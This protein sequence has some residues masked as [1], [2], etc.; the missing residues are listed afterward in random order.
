[1]KKNKL[2]V[3][4]LFAAGLFLVLPGA[5]TYPGALASDAGKIPAE[6]GAVG[7]IRVG[8]S[9]FFKD[10]GHERLWTGALLAIDDGSAEIYIGSTTEALVVANR[11]VPGER[12]ILSAVSFYTSG[13]AVGDPAEIIVYEDPTGRAPAPD[14]SMEVLRQE[15]TLGQGGF[16]GVDIS[17]FVLNAAGSPEA[18]FFVGLVNVAPRSFSLGIDMS[19]AGG[20]SFI[21]EDGGLRVAPIAEFPVIDGNAMIRVHRA[22][23]IPYGSAE[24][25]L[26]RHRIRAHVMGAEQAELTS[27]ETESFL[28]IGPSSG[29]ERGSGSRATLI[30]DRISASSGSESCPTC[31]PALTPGYPRFVVGDPDRYEDY[32]TIENSSGSGIVMPIRTILTSLTPGTVEAYNPDGGGGRPPT[33]YWDYSLS[34]A[35]GTDSEDDI[36]DPG[37]K[38]TRL[39]Q[40]ANDGGVLFEF[41]ADVSEV[42]TTTKLLLHGDGHEGTIG[43]GTGYAVFDGDG[44]SVLVAGSSSL[45]ATS[46]SLTGWVRFMD[47][48]SSNWHIFHKPWASTDVY[49]YTQYGMGWYSY[50]GN[51][52]IFDGAVNGTLRS[53]NSGITPQTHRW[54]FMVGTYDETELKVYVDGEDRGTT[55]APGTFSLSQ[56]QPIHIGRHGF[57]PWF[58][59]AHLFDLAV[60]SR[61]LDPLEISQL[62]QRGLQGLSNNITAGRVAYYPM[63]NDFDDQSGYGNHGAPQGDAQTV[64]KSRAG[65]GFLCSGDPRVDGDTKKFGHYSMNFDGSGDYLRFGDGGFEEWDFGDGDFT[66]DFWFYPTA[67]SRMA[68]FAYDTDHRL[69]IDFHWSGTRNINI[70]ASSTGSSWDLVYGDAGGNGIGSISLDLNEWHHV[71]YVRSGD[72]WITFIDGVKDVDVTVSGSVVEKDEGINIGRWGTGAYWLN[73]NIDEYRVSKGIARWTEDF[74]PATQPYGQDAYA[75]LLLHVDGDDSAYHRPAMLYGDPGVGAIENKW[76]GSLSFDGSGDY[77]RFAD[78]EDW[79][80]GSDDFTIDFWFYPKA[81]SRMALFAFDSDHRLGIDFHWAGTRNVNLWASSTGTSWNLIH[82]D[83]GGNGI[84]SVSLDLNKWHHV[85]FVRSG[86]RWMSFINGIRD[87]DVTV[88]GSVVER[89]EGINIGNWGGPNTFWLNGHVDEYRVSRGIAR[90]TENFTPDTEPY[91]GD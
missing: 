34:T 8:S 82:S 2:F 73:G 25:G 42:D 74:T 30:N 54:Y 14:P 46:V 85:A 58:L 57:L 3:T 72:R 29:G 31:A 28:H 79:D 38:I 62:H 48:A 24:A 20:C 50:E 41:W 52:L 91:G 26:M 59:D 6:I 7:E 10:Q 21:S 84:G 68:L 32:V 18:A 33:G 67:Q 15:I 9:P 81:E 51:T 49:P 86:D 69:G 44:D 35:D 16:Q 90:W 63:E 11:F 13:A 76:S 64:S 66:I 87:V 88:S 83:G 37:E 19:G 78:S 75:K 55:N 12:V 5:D 89:D 40:I 23:L 36:L 80:F 56:T 61:L 4:A 65:R 53:V 1:M 39:W 70:W 43:G 77:L 22:G 17:G 27:G 60:Y 45:N 47:N 71:A